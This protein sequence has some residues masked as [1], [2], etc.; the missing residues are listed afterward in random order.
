[1]ILFIGHFLF[2]HHVSVGFFLIFFLFEHIF[3]LGN[4]FCDQIKKI[5]LK[6]RQRAYGRLILTITNYLPSSL[7][8]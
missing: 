1:M 5:A 4:Y 3:P 2:L 8:N 6:L 7:V